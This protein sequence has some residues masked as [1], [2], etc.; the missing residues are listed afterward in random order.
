MEKVVL[1]ILAGPAESGLIHVVRAMLDFIY[2]AH[3][4]FH[5]LDSLWKLDAAWV[6]FHKNLQYFVDKGVQKDHNNFNIPKLHSM[7]HYI[8]SIISQGFADS[9]N[10]QS[11][12]CLHIDFAKNAYQATNKR[13]F[14]KQIIKWLERQDACFQFSAYLQWAVERYTVSLRP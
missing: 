11:P 7:H 9:F 4:E 13:N 10:T 8:D 12:E 14:V 5:T 6:A 1:S 3:F 2:Y